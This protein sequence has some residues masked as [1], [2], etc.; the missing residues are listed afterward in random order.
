MSL[1]NGCCESVNGTSKLYV[2]SFTV[3]EEAGL[4]MVAASNERQAFEVLQHSGNRNSEM[5]SLVQIRD[6]GM[7]SQMHYG[8]LMESYVNALEAFA[9]IV[10]VAETMKG[11]KGD[12]GKDGKDGPPGPEGP[13]GPAGPTVQSDWFENNTEALDY[14]K[15]RTINWIQSTLTSTVPRLR[16]VTSQ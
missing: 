5:Y 15:N 11:P 4:A 14:I 9:A 6:I 12:D 2:I 10:K 7:T 3:G 13:Q 1:M 16:A 8:L